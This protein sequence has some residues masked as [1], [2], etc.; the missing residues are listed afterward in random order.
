[1]RGPRVVPRAVFR[2]ALVAAPLVVG[3][4]IAVTMIP[5]ITNCPSCPGDPCPCTTDYRLDVR[6][7]IVAVSILVAVAVWFATRRS[8]PS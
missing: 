2:W 4:V 7:P 8:R 3:V 5:R 1:M 6:L